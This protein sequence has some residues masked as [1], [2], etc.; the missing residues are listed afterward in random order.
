MLPWSLQARDPLAGQVSIYRDEY[1]VPHH[2]NV[3]S[4]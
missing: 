3:S 4:S 1:G 2:E